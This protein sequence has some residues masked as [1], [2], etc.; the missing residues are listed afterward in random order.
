MI[1]FLAGLLI[2]MVLSV[3]TMSLMIV[4]RESDEGIRKGH[5]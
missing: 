3:F 5:P 4:A 2:G 1:S